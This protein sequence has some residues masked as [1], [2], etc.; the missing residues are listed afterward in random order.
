MPSGSKDECQGGRQAKPA[1]YDVPP[2]DW[3]RQSVGE[4]ERTVGI[5]IC[6]TL[7]YDRNISLLGRRHSCP[8]WTVQDETSNA[9]LEL[10]KLKFSHD[11]PLRQRRIPRARRSQQFLLNITQ[12]LLRV[13]H[14][15]I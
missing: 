15:F 2:E 7:W 12:T 1:Q 13:Y 5:F 6:L 4:D 11:H 9:I 8:C 10:D 14:A 3:G